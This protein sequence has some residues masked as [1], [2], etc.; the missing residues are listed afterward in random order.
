MV[1]NIHYILEELPTY[2]R[3]IIL[4]SYI[5]TYICC[6]FLVLHER[7]EI[8]MLMEF[9][10]C[11]IDNW[12]EIAY[13]LN[14]QRANI[15]NIALQDS[16]ESCYRSMLKHWLQYDTDATWKKYITILDELPPLESKNTTL[17]GM[18][19]FI[20]TYACT[21]VL[22]TLVDSVSKQLVLLKTNQ[23]LLKSYQYNYHIHH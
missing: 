14:L 1:A 12:K 13:N 9:T 18:C 16:P 6:S 8:E 5:F 21:R 23:Y 4:V 19:F 7:P 20:C 11:F 22:P 2:I 10:S 3:V 17:Y 15:G